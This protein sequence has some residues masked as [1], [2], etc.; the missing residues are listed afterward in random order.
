MAMQGKE[1]W[2]NPCP[3][4]PGAGHRP[5]SCPLAM[6]LAPKRADVVVCAGPGR[7]GLSDGPNAS[8]Q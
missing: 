7:W 6:A 8:T 4:C 3:T 2:G 5:S 1:G